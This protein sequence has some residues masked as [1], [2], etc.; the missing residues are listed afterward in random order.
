MTTTTT[1]HCNQKIDGNI[2]VKGHNAITATII[3]KV[4]GTHSN[5]N[6]YGE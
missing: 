4:I 1:T 6:I 5:E 3:T 2:E